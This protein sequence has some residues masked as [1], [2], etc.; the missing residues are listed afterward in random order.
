MRLICPTSLWV[1]TFPKLGHRLKCKHK[2]Q[3]HNSVS[4]RS[5]N[6]FNMEEF[7]NNLHVQ[8]VKACITS[9]QYEASIPCNKHLLV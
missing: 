6:M 3:Q 1:M 7:Q 8:Q 4:Y 9:N 2:K 5:F